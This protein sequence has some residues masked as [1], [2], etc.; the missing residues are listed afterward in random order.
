MRMLVVLMAST[1]L[2][3]ACTE[4]D[5]RVYFSGNYYPTKA[6]KAK[7]DR[8]AFTVTVRRA[9]QGIE[10]ARE[11]GRHGAIRYC[12]ETFG[13]SGIDWSVGPDDNAAITAGS[14]GSLVMKGR[15]RIWE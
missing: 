14:K 4:K 12:V 3:S 13:Y 8:E 1:L 11:A 15:C 6:K 7:G 9:S 5:K 10:G 2:L